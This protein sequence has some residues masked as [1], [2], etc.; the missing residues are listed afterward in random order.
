MASPSFAWQSPRAILK[1]ADPV[2]A[3]ALPAIRETASLRARRVVPAR[4]QEEY[5]PGGPPPWR[6]T[7]PTTRNWPGGEQDEGRFAN[8]RGCFVGCHNGIS[9]R[10]NIRV[11]YLPP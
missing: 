8:P 3:F 6:A 10:R 9:S 1:L 4:G 7:V 11:R 2:S 5:P